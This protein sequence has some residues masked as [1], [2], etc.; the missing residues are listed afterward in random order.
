MICSD[1]DGSSPAPHCEQRGTAPPS[2]QGC[3]VMELVTHGLG[4]YNPACQIEVTFI[5]VSATINPGECHQSG[6]SK[7]LPRP[8]V[9]PDRPTVAPSSASSGPFGVMPGLS[10]ASSGS[11]L[12]TEEPWSP[13]PE[14]SDATDGLRA[15]M[16]E[17]PRLSRSLSSATRELSRLTP[18]LA[19]RSRVPPDA[20]QVHT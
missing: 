13:A 14:L 16:P 20:S 1:R 11:Y 17:L 9:A 3:Q 19:E 8:S 10:S 12:A 5:P 4:A 15:V 2:T 18:G 7:V 6:R